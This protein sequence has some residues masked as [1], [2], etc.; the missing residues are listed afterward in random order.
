MRRYLVDEDGP[1]LS[2]SNS[3]DAYHGHGTMLMYDSPSEHNGRNTG[4][5]NH[6][7]VIPSS[8]S[9]QINGHHPSAHAPVAAWGPALIPDQSAHSNPHLDH[10]HA[11]IAESPVP[12]ARDR[13]TTRRISLNFAAM[14]PFHSS[15]RV[16][17]LGIGMGSSR[18]AG[19][20]DGED[21]SGSMSN[22]LSSL[23]NMGRALGY[24]FS[25]HDKD[26]GLLLENNPFVTRALQFLENYLDT[27]TEDKPSMYRGDTSHEERSSSID[28]KVE[29]AEKDSL[30][31][32]EYM[33][34]HL[35]LFIH[36]A[37]RS[38]LDW[39][40]ASALF[41]LRNVTT[42]FVELLDLEEDLKSGSVDRPQLAMAKCLD[43]LK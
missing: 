18:A 42:L 8:R 36:H 41:E 28:C 4:L 5:A 37:A 11:Q 21:S 29:E 15:R 43:K 40:S 14:N 2:P 27:G 3:T 16:S 33:A 35:K 13:G 39:S 1:R 34:S 17:H 38:T 30:G 25:E 24:M 20:H 19:H 26:P 23:A 9:D 10:A 32:K 7:H 31:M 22:N 6:S 12:S